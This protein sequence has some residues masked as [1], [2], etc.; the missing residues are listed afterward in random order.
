MSRNS[1]TN[2][3]PKSR[4]RIQA[5][6]AVKNWGDVPT[7]TLGR[8]AW[9][10]PS[11]TEERKNERKLATRLKNPLFGAAYSQVRS[12]PIPSTSSWRSHSPL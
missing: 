1:K 7:T 4:L 9:I 2:G 12:T 6:A 8:G 11:T 3:T 10:R 5:E